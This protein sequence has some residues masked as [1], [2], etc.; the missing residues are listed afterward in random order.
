MYGTISDYCQKVCESISQESRWE[1][2][3]NE[4]ILGFFSFNKFLLWRDL[5]PKNWPTEFNLLDHPIVQKL[6]IPPV[7][8]DEPG[9]PIVS[10]GELIDHFFTP[11]DLVYVMDADSSQT[12]AIQT[13]FKWSKYGYPMA[14]WHW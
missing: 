11:Q 4:I 9:Q 2:L 8:A 6:L 7:Q 5:D 3:Q 10:N 12:E 14:A 13:V 1:V